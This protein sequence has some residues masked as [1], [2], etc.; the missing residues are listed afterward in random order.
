MT[1]AYLDDLIHQIEKDEPEVLT[2]DDSFE[3]V[4]DVVEIVK[5]LSRNRTIT[6]VCVKSASFLSSKEASEL[7]DLL[8]AGRS[9][10]SLQIESINLTVA[11]NASK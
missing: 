5:P 7:R 6:T 1:R 11:K 8:R 4:E 3:N 10:R 2:L 9:I